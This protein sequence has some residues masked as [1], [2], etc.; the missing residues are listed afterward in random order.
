MGTSD[1][2]N[3]IH[4]TRCFSPSRFIAT[5]SQT[6][7]WMI[8]NNHTPATQNLHGDKTSSATIDPS[9]INLLIEYND[10]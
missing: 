1:L 10:K 7:S 4:G 9:K 6:N 8:L 3:N 2:K 5:I